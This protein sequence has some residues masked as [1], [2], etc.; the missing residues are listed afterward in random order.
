MD[1]IIL[2][3]IIGAGILDSFNPCAISAALLFIAVMFTLGRDRKAILKVGFF[4]II[5]VYLTYFFIGLGLLETINLFG[6]PHL[7]SFIG[8]SIVILFGVLNLKEYFFPNWNFLKIRMPI[9]A[10]YKLNDWAYKASVPA[11]VVMGI[12]VGI[13]EFPCSGAVYIAIISLL[14]LKATFLNGLIYLLIYNL[15]FVMPLILIFVFSSNRMITERMINWQEKEGR[16][17][18]L[19]LAGVMIGLGTIMLVWYL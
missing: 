12:L 7:V 3:T 4:Y 16:K 19:L 17:M 6:I 8:A 1:N 14:N 10:R 9:S 5:S 13:F 15:L 2:P 11:A 18:H